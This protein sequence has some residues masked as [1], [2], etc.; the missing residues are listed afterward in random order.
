MKMINLFENVK[1]SINQNN[2]EFQ[3]EHNKKLQNI[4][5]ERSIWIEKI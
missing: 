5:L 2:L 4:F 3:I 1:E